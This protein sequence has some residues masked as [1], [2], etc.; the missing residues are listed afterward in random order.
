MSLPVKVQVSRAQ[1]D[2]AR[3]AFQEIEIQMSLAHDDPRAVAA[4]KT[5]GRRTF[6]ALPGDCQNMLCQ[7][8][9]MFADN[10]ER[11]PVVESGVVVPQQPQL[12]PGSPRTESRI[13]G[14][15]L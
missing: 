3:T 15:L 14:G 8:R 5:V 2:L 11:S 6:D 9:G 12:G 4:L 1:T 10:T 13:F 7:Y